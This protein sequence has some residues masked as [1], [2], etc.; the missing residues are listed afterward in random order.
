[1]STQQPSNI[2][3]ALTQ[4]LQNILETNRIALDQLN[5]KDQDLQHGGP[6]K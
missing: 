3:E 5:A 1:M 2:K 4:G 6:S